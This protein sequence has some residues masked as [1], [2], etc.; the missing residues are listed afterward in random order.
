MAQTRE[1]LLLLDRVHQGADIAAHSEI[2]FGGM[3]VA[4][5]PFYGLY[6]ECLEATRTQPKSWK[7]F[8]RAQRAYIFARYV[9]RFAL[10]GGPMVECGVFNGFSALLA[11]RVLERL[12]PGYRGAELFLVDSFAGLS[13]PAR[14]DF[15]AI[16]DA[17]GGAALAP[18][19]PQGHFAV[20]LDVVMPRFAKYPEVSFVRGWIPPVLAALPERRWSFVH[21]DVDLHEPTLACLEYFIPRMAPGGVIV[22]D[23]FS[24]PLFPG[25]GRAWMTWFDAH[26]APYIVLDSGQSVY[27]APG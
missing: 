20:G 7:V 10:Q 6:R 27:V 17:S 23:D 16:N 26:P 11:C 24:S 19:H 13:A 18:S 5:A 8:R 1:D 4:G 2:L 22:N 25:G 14:E 12:R 21:I 9:E 15:V 3:Q